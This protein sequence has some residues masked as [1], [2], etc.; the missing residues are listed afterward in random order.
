LLS[1]DVGCYPASV[2]GTLLLP[3]PPP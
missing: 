3:S 1:A 2:F